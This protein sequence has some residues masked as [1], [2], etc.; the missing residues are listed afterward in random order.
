MVGD[1]GLFG[2]Y[3][4]KNA[5][6]LAYLGLYSLQHRGQESA[7]IVVGDHKTLRQHKGLGL[8]TDVFSDPATL[9]DLAGDLAVGHTRYSTTGSPLPANIQPLL[10]NCKGGPL[11]IAHNGNLVNSNALRHKL[12]QEGSLFQTTVDSEVIIHLTARSQ[13]EV[14]LQRMIEA[15]RQV[16]GAYSILAITKD[17]I[18][19]V[20]DPHGFRPLCLGKLGDAW[21]VASESCALD[22]IGG[23]YCRDV[24][25][26]E[27]VIL[28]EDGLSSIK[29]FGS[30]RYAFC[31]FE[32]IY[33][34]RP[35]SKVFGENVD[36]ARRRLGRQLAVE[37]PAQADI[38]I[39]VP[40]SSNTAA[41]GY[42]E[43]SG[44]KFELGLIRN[45]YIGRTFIE[46]RSEIRDIMVRIK[47]NP[48]SGLLKGKSVVVVEDSI[49][50][51]TTMRN[52]AG[53]IREAGAKEVHVR[54]S[55]PPLRF[56]CYYGIDFQTKDE[57]IASSKTVEQIRNFL[58]VITT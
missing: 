37:H 17:K 10:V 36:K 25:P 34:S 19:A 11:A 3:G 54:V 49:V 26:G 43:S 51:G 46:P 31:I 57:L 44:I 1:C 7:G 21:V 38:V 39:S 12:E 42:S 2:I 28:S 6:D 56:P 55:C 35:D 16:R 32:Y 30:H 29:P 8:V 33:F 47:F 27:I 14:L 48:V 53:L 23:K 9:K 58:Q 20:R 15:L 22:I 18:I 45:H 40:D 52:L 24:E 5:A 41:L 50:R 13:R 4:H